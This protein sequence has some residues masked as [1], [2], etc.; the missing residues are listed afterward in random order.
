MCEFRCHTRQQGLGFAN[1]GLN[2]LQTRI[3][4]LALR[5]TTV[6]MQMQ[7]FPE[8]DQPSAE[9]AAGHRDDKPQNEEHSGAGVQVVRQINRDNDRPWRVRASRERNTE[10]NGK[11][12]QLTRFIGCPTAVTRAVLPVA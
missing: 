11:V 12:S 9:D 8:I 6:L 10:R 2:N 4:R 5:K 7:A 1:V 3:A